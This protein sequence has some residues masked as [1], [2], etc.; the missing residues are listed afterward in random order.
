MGAFEWVFNTPSHHRVHHGRNPEYLDRNHGGIF[1][2]WDRIFGTFEAEKHRPEYGLTT[3]L[4][5]YN[6]V[7]IAFH[8]WWAIAQDVRRAQTWRG[9]FG[10]VFGP[11]GWRED[12][13]GQTSKVLRDEAS[14]QKATTILRHTRLT[15]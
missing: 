2:V 4:D 11:P 9:R 1:I 7:V 8:E 12:G 5:S 10:Y 6:P 13:M 15:M 14:S 3:N